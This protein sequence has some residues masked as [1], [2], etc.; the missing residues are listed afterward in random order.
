VRSTFHAYAAALAAGA[1]TSIVLLAVTGSAAADPVGL[2]LFAALVLAGELLPVSV[3]RGEA[4]EE[5]TV[6]APFALAMIPLFGALPAVAVYALVRVVIDVARRTE[7]AKSAFNATQAVLALSAAAAVYALAGG[8]IGELDV[9]PLLAAGAAFLIADNV[10]ADLG[11][12]FYTRRP[13]ADYLRRD[14]AFHVAT[15]GA[16]VCLAPVVVAVAGIRLSLVPLLAVP[17]LAVHWG[18]RQSVENVAASL[19]DPLTGMPN[20]IFLT[21]RLDTW[22]EDARREAGEVTVAVCAVPELPDYLGELDGERGDALVRAL[23]QRFADVAGPN[24]SAAALGRG[25][26]AAAWRTD[27]GPDAAE[28]AELVRERFA[29]PVAIGALELP[30][31]VRVGLARAGANG[32]TG[33]ALVRAADLAL[34]AT[35]PESDTVLAPAREQSL[36]RLAL[37]T[38]LKRGLQR[39]E[40]VVHYQA[41]YPLTVGSG[42]AA[43]A[44]VRWNHPELGQI[45][46]QGFVPLAERLGL[47]GQ[48]TRVVLAAAIEQCADWRARGLAV[49]VAVNVPARCLA[50]DS[51]PRHIDMLLD[52]FGVPADALQLEVTETELLV[53]A[54]ATRGVLDRLADA[55]IGWAIDDFGTGYSSL[56]QL[57]R[58]PVEE[59]KIDR[60]FV[61]HLDEGGAGDAIVRSTIDLAKSLG[62]RVTA[63][64]VESERVLLRLA[65]LGCD[66]A[67]GFH[68]GR[69]G[70]ADDCLAAFARRERHAPIATG[71]VGA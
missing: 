67:Q 60:S 69:P 7:L 70:P 63:E 9:E 1:S 56:A 61:R 11:A 5:V 34:G 49:R 66:Y 39:G 65:E 28:L 20:R 53:E 71:A 58:M 24:C 43:E 55:G 48:L 50:D 62:L 68:L 57:Q 27:A 19:H 29:A 52:R 42:L 6:S 18:A 30:V 36:D 2:T 38:D 46:P 12:A 35:S 40:L 23:G 41:K 33:E 45:A 4:F 64:G 13:I 26:F 25:H 16:L 15:S 59:L 32:S 10:L 14:I 31:G 17:V 21:R 51:L 54:T 47:I 3:P 44:L 22:I 37:A 8:R